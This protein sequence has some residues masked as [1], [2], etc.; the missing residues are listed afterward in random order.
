[1]NGSSVEE[2]ERKDSEIL[3]MKRAYEEFLKAKI[4]TEKITDL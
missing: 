4:L 1:L 3:Y 2:N